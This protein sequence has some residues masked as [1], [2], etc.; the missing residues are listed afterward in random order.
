MKKKKQSLGY[1]IK[2]LGEQNLTRDQVEIR[3][4]EIIIQNVLLSFII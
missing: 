4:N 3:H 1:E 2:N